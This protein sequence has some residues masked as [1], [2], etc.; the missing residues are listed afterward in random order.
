MSLPRLLLALFLPVPSLALA[1]ERVR[2][3]DL[4]RT[5]VTATQTPESPFDTPY[6]VDRIGAEE[7][8]RSG[9]RTTPD[10]LRETPGILL[11]A[12]SHG[13]GSPYIRGF[14]GFRTVLLIDGIRLNNSVFRDGPNQYW[15]TVDPYSIRSL[16]VVKGPSSVLWGSDAIGGTV[17]ALTKGP[18]SWGRGQL[19]TFQYR[20]ASAENSHVGRVEL[21]VTA[22]D[23]FGVLVGGTGKTYGDLVAGDDTG[24]QP[25]TGY[26]EWNADVKSEHWLSD[27]TRLVVAY[28]EVKQNDVPRTHST[29]KA[30]S[31]EGTAVGGDRRRDLDQNRQL[32]YTQLIG[33]DYKVSLS[34]QKQEE[35]RDRI[36]GNGAREFQG[37]DVDTVGMFGHFTRP[38]SIGTL[39]FGLDYYHDDVNSFSST[40][41]IQG[42]VGDDA[43]YDLAGAYA[44]SEIEAGER[45]SLVLGARFNYAAAEADKVQDPTGPGAI[46]IDDDWTRVVGSARV[47]YQGSDEVHFYGGVSQGFRAPNL[48]DLTRFDTARSNEFEIASPGL[49][50]EK[51]LSYEVGVKREDENGAGDLAVFYT[52]IEDPIVR[53][54]TGNTNA[55]GDFEIVKE[56]VG[57]GYAFGVELSAERRLDESWTLFGNATYMDGKADTFPTSAPVIE[58]EYLDRLMPTNVL[59]GVGWEPQD[60]DCHA[61]GTLRW[62][63]DADRLSTRDER[64]TQRIPLG[65]TPGYVL[66][67]LAGGTSLGPHARIEVALDNLLDEDYRI[68]GSGSNSAGRNLIVS[69]TLTN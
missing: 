18:T 13:Q 15:N 22:G 51:Y 57:D 21:D 10:M 63:D 39:T 14:T 42:P 7:L 68:H 66:L 35:E 20:V 36:R 29:N 17:N 1:Q 43:T 30:V 23:D 24:T 60:G 11:Q 34:W 16:E 37:F 4:G 8:L 6:T 33:P 48:S 46:S 3:T 54:P 25:N 67:G 52:D 38:S 62:V 28:Q 55:A 32:G 31:F 9:A 44:Q 41:P 2:E 19:G 27:D 53:F 45:T 49:D 65:G 12:T 40:N 5:I 26:D 56:N 50:P 61:R 64:D 59:V 58:E 47:L 69:L